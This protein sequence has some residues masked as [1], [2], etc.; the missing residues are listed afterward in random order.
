MIQ[1]GI[2]ILYFIATICVGVFSRKTNTANAY[3]GFKLSLL[4]CVAVGAGEWMGGTSTTGVSEYGYLYGISGAWYTV[5]NGL[6]ICF[7]ALFFARLFR[8][9]NTSTVPEIIGRYLGRQA[10][11]VSSVMLTLVLMIVGV[12]QLIAVGT[13]G[14]SLLH[15]D[16][17]LS[18]LILGLGVLVYTCLGGMNAIGTTN[19]LHMIVMYA[20]GVCERGTTDAI[21]YNPMHEYTRGLMRSIPDMS[22]DEK[23]RLVPITRTPID[24]LRMPPGCPFAPRCDRAMK[25]CL[26]EKPQEYWVG[27][28]HLSACWM[29]VKE[30]KCF[31][32]RPEAEKG[33]A[34]G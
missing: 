17:E 33:E 22:D 27:H 31:A 15:L 30:G 2:I 32:E 34:N 24:L 28:D 7:L 16:S 21:F 18:I 6:G 1:A 23:T 29:N 19:V 12:S 26:K 4:M 20:G 5:A 10:R 3:E 13:L 8:S 11:T 9:L 25:I 14:E